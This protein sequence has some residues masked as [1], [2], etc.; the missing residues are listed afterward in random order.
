MTQSREFEFGGDSFD[1]CCEATFEES[2]FIP[3]EDA[4]DGYAA[5]SALATI[6]SGVGKDKYRDFAGATAD[7]DVIIPWTVPRDIDLTEGIK[8]RVIGYITAETPPAVDTQCVVFG[9]Q[10]FSLGI[11]DPLDCVTGFPAV[12][13]SSVSNLFDRGCIQFDYYTT[14]DSG[15][16]NVTDLAA[17]ERVIFKMYRDQDHGE[18]TYAQE[19]GVTGVVLTYSRTPE[20]T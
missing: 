19:I 13:F 9:L 20:P 8:F 15:E 5:P 3:I 4:I 1:D 16:V 18:A 6:T 2:V 11:G 10:G 14:V 12:V 17:G 7:E